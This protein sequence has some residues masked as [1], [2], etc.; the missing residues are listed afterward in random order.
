MRFH[1]IFAFAFAIFLA[2]MANASAE[3]D[4]T[5]VEVNP[6]QVDNQIDE[7]VDFQGDCS[8]CQNDED[9]SYFYWNSSIDGILKEG[10][11]AGEI[12]FSKM[13]SEFTKGS[14]DITLQVKDNNGDWSAIDSDS[15]TGLE[16]DGKDGSSDIEV[17]FQIGSLGEPVSIFLKGE[18]ITSVVRTEEIAEKTSESVSYTHLTL[19]TNREV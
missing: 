14:H 1:V 3:P 4:V 9:F 13:S 7:Q 10:I 6:S 5:M 8:I 15:T 2:V 16:V 11:S 17:N 19:P 18:D 12:M